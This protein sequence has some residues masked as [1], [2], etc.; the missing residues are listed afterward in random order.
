[1][2]NFER[3]ADTYVYTLF[4]SAEPLISTF[5]KIAATSGEPP[6]RPNWHHFSIKSRIDYLKK[7]ESDK[8][9][10]TRHDNKIKKSIAIYLS[11][12]ILLCGVG[13]NLSFGESSKKL[14]K[15]FF[16]KIIQREIEKTPNNPLLYSSLG[17]LYYSDKNYE[18]TI[19]A[20]EQAIMIDPNNTHAL[21]NL[22]WL[23][24][25]C[26]VESFRDPKQ[27]LAL[28]KRAV[29][30]EVSPHI[31]DTLAESFYVNGQIEQAII[32]ETRALEISIKNRDYYKKQ[33][34][35]FKIAMKK[36]ILL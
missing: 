26:E 32:T 30:L 29:Q 22:A 20:Y 3:Q 27:A 21:N 16:L 10:I 34:A 13:Y 18:D 31:L 5:K 15:H 35:K 9:W 12:V 4:D 28:A 33:L 36:S 25:T 7:C 6:D 17:D 1:M 14:N 11:G 8:I 24:A 23:F 19:K 2:R